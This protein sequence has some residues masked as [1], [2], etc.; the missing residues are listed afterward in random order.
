MDIPG[1]LIRLRAIEETDLERLSRWVNDPETQDSIG[2]IHPPSSMAF[3]RSWLTAREDEEDALRLAVDLAGEGIIGISSLVDI[4]W[5]NRH[6]WHGLVIGDGGH[7]RR[8]L[9]TDAV[10]ATMRCAFEEMN[11][12]R[13]DGGMIEYNLASCAAYCG[14]RLG[15]REVGRRADYFFRKG[16]YWDQ[17]LVGITRDEYHALCARTRYWG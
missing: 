12:K 15:W 8:G 6:A 13:L 11:L 1:R 17:V 7:R 14:E 2:E 10:M 5:R 16:R 9:G 3:H 4:D